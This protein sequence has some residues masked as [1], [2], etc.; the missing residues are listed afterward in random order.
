MTKQYE[1]IQGHYLWELLNAYRFDNTIRCNEMHNL[2][3]KEMRVLIGL[4]VHG[5]YILEGHVYV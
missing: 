4:S 3:S 1:S 5:L 2:I